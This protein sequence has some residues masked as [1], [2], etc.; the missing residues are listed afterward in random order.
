MTMATK[1]RVRLNIYIDDEEM[2]RQ[3]KI[4]AARRDMT[5]TEYCK[6]AIAEQLRREAEV[7]WAKEPQPPEASREEKLAIIQRMD[8]A[9]RR[10]GPI[11]VSVTELI[12]EGRRR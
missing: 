8:E 6:R 1:K 2:R 3:V 12:K 9:R 5:V 10:T 11:G 4:A 7:S